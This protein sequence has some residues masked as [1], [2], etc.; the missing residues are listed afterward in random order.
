MRED[1]LGLQLRFN[2]G[3]EVIL[4]TDVMQSGGFRGFFCSRAT[5]GFT[6][7]SRLMLDRFPWERGQFHVLF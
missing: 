6:G 1:I 2:N 7:F 3:T 5:Q 4:G